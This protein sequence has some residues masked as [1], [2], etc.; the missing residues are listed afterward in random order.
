MAAGIHQ[1]AELILGA[2]MDFSYLSFHPDQSLDSLVHNLKE[3]IGEFGNDLPC[4]VMVDLFGGSPANSIVQLLSEGYEL[5]TVTGVNLPMVI[6]AL[7]GRDMYIPKE[8]I[9]EIM[10]EAAEGIIDI[11]DKLTEE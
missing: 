9:K 5:Q 6:S 8:L 11:V 7:T 10:R 3:K 4:L 2:Q 1:T